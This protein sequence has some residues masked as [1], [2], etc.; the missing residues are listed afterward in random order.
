MS[1][2]TKLTKIQLASKISSWFADFFKLSRPIPFSAP[3][4]QSI[5]LIYR[6]IA[7]VMY[8]NRY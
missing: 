4:A 7:T 3:Y 1:I 6:Y 5:I 8:I 2:I